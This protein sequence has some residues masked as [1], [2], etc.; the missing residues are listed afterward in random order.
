MLRIVW[1]RL[2]IVNGNRSVMGIG[3]RSPTDERFPI[4]RLVM[5]VILAIFFGLAGL[6]HLIA[7]ADFP[8]ITP[9]WVPFAPAVI[10]ITG[11]FELACAAALLTRSL[12]YWAGFAL[13]I[14]SVCVWPANFK[15]AFEGIQIAHVPSTWLYHAPRLALQPVIIWSSLFGAGVT[16]WPWRKTGPI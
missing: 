8:K 16:D 9:N 15:H 1:F 13:A 6:A 7:P 11:L 14:Y 12:R 2:Q 5:R 10:A 4:T 3:S